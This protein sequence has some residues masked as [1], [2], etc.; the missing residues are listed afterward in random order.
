VLLHHTGAMK[1]STIMM[2]LAALLLL[3]AE[4]TAGKQA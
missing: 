1:R 4:L 3:L 2:Y